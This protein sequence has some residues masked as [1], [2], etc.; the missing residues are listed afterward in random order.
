MVRIGDNGRP[1]WYSDGS[2]SNS[3]SFS[4]CFLAFVIAGNSLVQFLCMEH[5]NNPCVRGK[6]VLLYKLY[7][8][9]NLLLTIWC[10]LRRDRP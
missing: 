2:I 5:G 4:R 10:L 8:S 6:T 3:C 7:R 9:D 1:R